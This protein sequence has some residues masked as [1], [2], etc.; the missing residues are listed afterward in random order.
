MIDKKEEGIQKTYNYRDKRKHFMKGT[1][2]TYHE[3]FADL[4]GNECI[5][6]NQ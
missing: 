4:P 5:T 3:I 1:E 2:I 6:G